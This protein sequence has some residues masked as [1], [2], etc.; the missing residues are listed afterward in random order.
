MLSRRWNYTNFSF[1]KFCWTKRR[2]RWNS[3]IGCSNKWCRTES[4]SKYSN[5]TA[6]IS[7]AQKYRQIYVNEYWVHMNLPLKWKQELTILFLCFTFSCPVCQKQYS[8]TGLRFHM[9]S[10]DP[11]E[12]F[13]L[14]CDLCGKKFSRKETILAHIK[15]HQNW[16]NLDKTK[17]QVPCPVCKRV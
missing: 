6:N 4:W 10:H 9:P 13:I 3:H 12:S 5:W 2:N 14:E 1:T 16:K 11:E 7:K 15:A 17:L 8:R